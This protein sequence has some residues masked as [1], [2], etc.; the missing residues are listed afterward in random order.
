MLGEALTSSSGQPSGL[1]GGELPQVWQ[2][3]YK[4][5]LEKNIRRKTHSAGVV[6]VF[7]DFAG[8]TAATDADTEVGN[9]RGG[10]GAK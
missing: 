5:P 3:N 8:M 4:D 1:C 6:S 7:F 10:K 2:R 9:G